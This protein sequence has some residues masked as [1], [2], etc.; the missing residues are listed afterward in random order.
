MEFIMTTRGE[1]Q[2]LNDRYL[3]N[4]RKTEDNGNIYWERVDRRSGNGC[5]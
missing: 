3:Y 4:K 5:G 2:L 1:R